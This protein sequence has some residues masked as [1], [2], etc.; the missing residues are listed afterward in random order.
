MARVQKFP[1]Q[2]SALVSQDHYDRVRAIEGAHPVSMGDVLRD[3]IEAG[4]PSVEAKYA[5]L[6]AEVTDGQPVS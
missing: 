1:E 2:I 6:A 3:I 4:L 5:A